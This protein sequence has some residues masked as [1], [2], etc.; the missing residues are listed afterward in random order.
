LLFIGGFEFG[1]V[2]TL[3]LVTEAA[4]GARGRAIGIGNAVGTLARSGSVVL[5]GLLYERVGVGGSLALAT[6][7][8]VLAFGLIAAGAR[9]GASTR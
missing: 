2:S 5:T 6:V 8:G 9:L 1:F 4:P 3:S 7:W